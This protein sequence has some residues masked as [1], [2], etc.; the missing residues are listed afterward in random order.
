MC[1]LHRQIS[2]KLYN[3]VKIANCI[4]MI[5]INMSTNNHVSGTYIQV[6]EFGLA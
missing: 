3:N 5:G 4:N 1:G 6:S 2:I